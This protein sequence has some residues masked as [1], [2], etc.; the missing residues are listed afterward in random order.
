MT[1]ILVIGVLLSGAVSRVSADASDRPQVWSVNCHAGQSIAR[2]VQRAAPGDT[3]VVTGTCRERVVITQ[4]VNLQGH[5]TA[6]VDGSGAARTRATLSELDG[7]IV[8]DGA[9]GVALTGLTV[10]NGRSNGIVATRGAAVM[11]KDVIAEGNTLMGISVSDNSILEAVDSVTRS[12]G[13]SGFDV[14]TSSS[15]ILS[16]SFTT[17]DNGGSGGEINGQS[18]VELRG[19]QVTIANNP[20]FGIIAGSQSQLAIFGFEAARGS[21]LTVSG[22]GAAGIGLAGASSLTLFSDTVVT[23]EGNGVGILVA[24]G[25]EVDSPPFS[26]SRLLL[27]S[28]DV[29]MNVVA[30]AKVFAYAGLEIHH[31]GIGVLVDEASLHLEPASG[32]PASIAG[33]DTDVQL[34]FGTRSTIEHVTVGTALACESS[35]LSRGT[36]TCP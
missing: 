12:N 31:N 32:L 5:G 22:A 29:G 26:T 10:R 14:F 23:A 9:T 36:V 20:A 6:V 33:N 18:I 8:V 13:V 19:A 17:S 35:V 21:T 3:I 15:L 11:A 30:G 16:G 25:G 27:R 2:A 4:S 24:A 28:N 1:R 34:L 7:V